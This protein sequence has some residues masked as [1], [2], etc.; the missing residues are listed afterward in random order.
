MKISDLFI[1][2]VLS[3]FPFSKTLSNS[4]S[5]VVKDPG[6]FEILYSRANSTATGA[7]LGGF[8]GAAVESGV[9]SG[10]DQDREAL[11]LPHLQDSSCS[12]QVLN[13]LTKA[14]SR[15]NIEA[16][17]IEEV[18]DSS[19]IGKT[20][21][22]ELSGCGFKLTDS[23]MML[24]SAYIEVDAVLKD[25]SSEVLDEKI[26]I[27]GREQFTFHSLSENPDALNKQLDKVRTKAGKRIAN[28]IIYL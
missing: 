6:E 2:A 23:T 15:K 16:S 21:T 27:Q 8:I 7:V 28:K 14:L 4:I 10:Q 22:L 13:G 19:Q 5:V 3:V 9:R 12:S 20:L 18:S 17:V 26:L 25:G 11:I 24:V 1:I